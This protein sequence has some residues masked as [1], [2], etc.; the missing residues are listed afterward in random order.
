MTIND[1]TCFFAGD[2]AYQPIGTYIVEE[3]SY[4]KM[5]SILKKQDGEGVE[6]FEKIKG[7]QT[8][9]E[10]TYLNK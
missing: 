2:G 6:Y 9:S 10:Q 8:Y 3:I 5:Y 7:F 4:K 1:C